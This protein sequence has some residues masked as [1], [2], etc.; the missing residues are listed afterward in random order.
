MEENRIHLFLSYGHETRNSR[1]IDEIVKVLGKEF[2]IWKDTDVIKENDDWRREIVR[3]ISETDLT[4]GLLSEYSTRD[5]GVCLDE[6]AISVSVPGRKLITV[7]L[8]NQDHVL[9]PSTVT[10]NQWLDL[11]Q[12]EQYID[13]DQWDAYF[14]PKMEIL[15]ACIKSKENYIFQGEISRLYRIL[16]PA[17]FDSKASLY[18]SNPSSVARQWLIEKVNEWVQN[19]SSDRFLLITGDAGTGKSHFSAVFQHYNPICAA[20]AFFEH[21]KVNPDYVKDL[22]RYLVYTLATRFPDYRYQVLNIFRMEGLIDENDTVQEA[23]CAEFFAAHTAESLFDRLM[24]IHMIDGSNINMA[25]VL[26]GLDEVSAGSSNPMID[27]LCSEHFA[28]LPA[29][30]KF[31]IT[32]RAEPSVMSPLQVLRPYQIDLNIETSNEDIEK[33]VVKRLSPLLE[34]GKISPEEIRALVERSNQMFLYAELACDTILEGGISAKEIIGMPAGMGGLFCRYFDRLFPDPADYETVKPFLRVICAFDIGLLSE[35]YLMFVTGTDSETLNRFY[36]MLRTFARSRMIEKKTYT[37]LFHKS[38]YDWFTDRTLSGKYY[39]DTAA[40]RH[41]IAEACREIVRTASENTDYEFL[42]NTYHFMMK[43]G[44]EEQL[45]LDVKLLHVIQLSANSRSDA[46]IYNEVT[47]KLLR[48]TEMT[49]DTKMYLLAMLSLVGWV[50]DVDMEDKKAADMIED[51]YARFPDEIRD[52]PEIHVDAE[53][54]RIYVLNSYKKNYEEAW[55]WADDLIRYIR[56]CKPEEL[57]EKNR[58]LAKAYYHRCMIE[59]RLNRFDDCI[60]SAE[61]A[62]ETAEF[63]YK[64]PRALRCLVYIVQGCAYRKKGE[65]DKAIAVLQKSLEYRLALYGFYTLFTANSY[66]NLIEALYSKAVDTDTDFDPV[67]YEYLENYRKIIYFVVGEKSQRIIYYYV[68][69]VKVCDRN[70]DAD[71]VKEYA[72]KVLAFR[73][74]YYE[75]QREEMK[76]ILKKYE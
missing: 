59:F 39:I 66:I 64:D 51:L 56:A 2:K 9:V 14:T 40:G 15:L 61:C 67:L 55:G 5:R 48:I 1:I 44:Q 30:V 16:K 42:T 38:L 11:S 71:K 73:T 72:G 52:D 8:E 18:I 3:G 68:M 23:K 22:I 50:Y 4:V 47:A 35:K 31:I 26:D 10:R 53:I 36:F 12:W 17:P 25:I 7:L 37:F 45:P 46:E 32:T 33:Y 63:G 43:Y 27:F 62:N 29:C 41:M 6:L 75:E 34:Q 57:P 70:G 58:K 74:N 21:G 13:T 20:G 24:C 69:Q 19:P 60:A 28:R 76:Q 65:H 49:G 54:N